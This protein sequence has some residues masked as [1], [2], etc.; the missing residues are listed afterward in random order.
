MEPTSRLQPVPLCVREPGTSS[1]RV[2][3]PRAKRGSVGLGGLVN[4]RLPRER[5]SSR[6]LQQ[7][8]ITPLA[9]V[10]EKRSIVPAKEV[11]QKRQEAENP[12]WTVRDACLGFSLNAIIESVFGS[13][14]YC[15]PVTLDRPGIVG[16][17]EAYG[18]VLSPRP[19]LARLSLGSLRF[20]RVRITV[21]F[22]PVPA[23]L[24]FPYCSRV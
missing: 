1:S 20:A 12:G 17:A 24:K 4:S 18:L 15:V 5:Y 11:T 3:S 22:H 10:S 8:P 21:D 2:I 9:S 23:S 14:P 16:I 13:F 6:Q 19:G 7:S